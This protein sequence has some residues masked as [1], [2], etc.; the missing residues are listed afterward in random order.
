MRI[1]KIGNPKWTGEIKRILSSVESG[2]FNGIEAEENNILGRDWWY[3]KDVEGNVG[4]L[5]WIKC[6][7]D[8]C[9][10]GAGEVAEISFCV[11]VQSRGKGILTSLIDQLD[12]L[13]KSK[14]EK[15]TVIT[16]VVR[17]TNPFMEVVSKAFIK[18]GFQ[19]KEYSS[20]V[21]LYKEI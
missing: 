3:L 19:S 6:G 9:Y 12:V 5:L 16:A 2:I 17:K 18:K 1:E 4:G 8:P 13:I 20:T 11:D 14:F 21:L 15:A 10:M 7:V